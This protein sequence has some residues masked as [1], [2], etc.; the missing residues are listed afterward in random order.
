MDQSSSRIQEILHQFCCVCNRTINLIS[1]FSM[2]CTK[3]LLDQYKAV[4]INGP[5]FITSSGISACG[6]VFQLH[7]K[8]SIYWVDIKSI[9]SPCWSRIVQWHAKITLIDSNKVIYHLFDTHFCK[10]DNQQS[11]EVSAHELIMT[12]SVSKVG[13]SSFLMKH[14]L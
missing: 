8:P 11:K 10:S 4:Q 5:K 13:F 6:T 9:P 12:V 3:S 1:S 14:K 7:C 2:N